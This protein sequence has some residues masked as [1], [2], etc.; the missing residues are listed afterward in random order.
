M[1]IQLVIFAGNLRS[2]QVRIWPHADPT[3]NWAKRYDSIEECVYELSKLCYVT[4][5]EG[6]VFLAVDSLRSARVL[7]TKTESD[8]HLLIAAGFTERKWKTLP[9]VDIKS[10]PRMEQKITWLP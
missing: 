5:Q 1:D 4:Q 6:S 10:G 9:C 7:N 8:P 3:F 2:C